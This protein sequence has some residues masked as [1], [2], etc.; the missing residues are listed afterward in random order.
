MSTITALPKKTRKQARVDTN[1]GHSPAGEQA[2]GSFRDEAKLPWQM[3]S[4]EFAAEVAKI[5]KGHVSEGAAM[6]QPLEPVNPRHDRVIHTISSQ[7]AKELYRLSAECMELARRVPTPKT[8]SQMAVREHQR[9]HLKNLSDTAA[10]LFWVEVEAEMN[11]RQEPENMSI[12]E[13]WKIVVEKEEAASPGSI[14]AQLLSGGMQP[15]SLEELMATT[16]KRGPTGGENGNGRHGS[17][18]HGG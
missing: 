10:R 14:I 12:C 13:G 1:H 3:N 15:V 11:H 17:N 4:A 5:Y 2:P 6:F 9:Q 7:V 18:G 16:L 8:R